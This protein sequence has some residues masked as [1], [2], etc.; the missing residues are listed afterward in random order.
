[1]HA[2]HASTTSVSATATATAT[3]F[4]P[5]QATPSADPGATCACGQT[6]TS[7]HTRCTR[8]GR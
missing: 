2:M 1:M 7:R 6:I 4:I 8:C 5:A 3:T